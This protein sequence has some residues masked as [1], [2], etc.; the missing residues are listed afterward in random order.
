MFRLQHT[1]TT[2]THKS[3]TTAQ[4]EADWSHRKWFQQRGCGKRER[5]LIW[6]FNEKM[7]VTNNE[8]SNTHTHTHAEAVKQQKIKKD[9]G[10]L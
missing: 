9:E 3:K 5:K 7:A 1:H 10:K 4:K 2:H 8:P 6:W